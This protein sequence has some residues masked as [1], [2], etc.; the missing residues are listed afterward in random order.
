[1]SEIEKKLLAMF[2][3]WIDGRTDNSE[4]DEPDMEPAEVIAWFGRHSHVFPGEHFDGV[5]DELIA[6]MMDVLREYGYEL[7]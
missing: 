6:S 2:R 7:P 1:M 3:T 4:E 5:S